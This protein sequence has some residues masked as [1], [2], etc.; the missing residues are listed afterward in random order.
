RFKEVNDTLG[1]E[2][3]DRLLVQISRRLTDLLGDDAVV[4]RLG[5]DEFAILLPAV[6]SP[7]AAAAVAEELLVA[8]ERP[9]AVGDLNLEVGAS[10]GVALAPVHGTDAATLLQRADVAMY[11]AKESRSGFEVYDADRD[12]YS[13]RRLMLAAE[14]RHAIE[15]G[16]LAIHYQPK[17]DLRTNGITGVEAL[18]RWHHPDYGFVPPDEFIPL[19]EHTGLIRAL[20]RWVLAASIAQCGQWQRRGLHLNVAVNLSVRALLDVGLPDEVDALL[21]SAGVA[22]S[23]LTLEITESSIMADP[24]RSIGVLN[25]LSELGT[26]LSIDDFGT[27]YSS[28]SYLKKLPVGEVKVDRSFVM[29]M[30]ADQDDA[31]I[32]R[33][34]IDLARNLGL[35]VVA[36]GVEDRPTWDQLTALGCDAAQGYYLGR[37]MPVVQLDRWLADHGR[38]SRSQL[39]QST[40]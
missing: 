12:E 27:G 31:V 40:G 37:P 24:V 7:T 33:S 16:Q 1:H 29:N 13:P 39:V 6:G 26:L 3:G 11:S 17:A 20:T 35:R 25:S 34:T 18:L 23:S 19:A 30:S 22:A 15:R 4:A 2:S 32:V 9:F 5:G 8:L 28:L 38:P 10:I 36:E 21:K 14:L